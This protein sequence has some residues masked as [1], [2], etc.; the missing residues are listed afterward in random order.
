M[1]KIGFVIIAASLYAC[2]NTR[3]SSDVVAI[4]FDNVKTVDMNDGEIIELEATDKS[5]LAYIDG[6]VIDDDKFFIRSRGEVF[7]FDR[8]GRHLFNVGTRGRAANEYTQAD[9]IFMRGDSLAVFDW[10]A[11]RMLFY[12]TDGGYLSNMTINGSEDEYPCRMIPLSSGGYIVENVFNGVPGIITPMFGR[13]NDDF[14]YEYSYSGFNRKDGYNQGCLLAGKENTLLYADFFSDSVYRAAPDSMEIAL[15]YR[16]DFGKHK[17]PESL[18]QGKDT[19]ELF[20]TSNTEEF[21]D[22]IATNVVCCNETADKFR[23]VFMFRKEV[24]YVEYDK[25]SGGVSTIMI[26]D[27]EGKLNT[28]TGL[29]TYYAEDGFYISAKSDDIDSN[30]VLVKFG[31]DVFE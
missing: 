8:S 9:C 30:P 11:R 22:N 18:K 31:Y 27:P 6:F 19:Y 29:F 5:L 15:A 13:M 21:T 3:Q 16:I 4:D 7:A 24:H 14:G 2:N 26:E 23:F 28:T 25:K 12:D 20:Q 10:Q 1:R 17:L